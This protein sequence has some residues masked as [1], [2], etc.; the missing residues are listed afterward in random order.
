MREEPCK[1]DDAIR[2][3]EDVEQVQDAVVEADRFL[4][5]AKALGLGLRLQLGRPAGITLPA[6]WPFVAQW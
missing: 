5:Q 4:D 1:V 6:P 2:F 3:D